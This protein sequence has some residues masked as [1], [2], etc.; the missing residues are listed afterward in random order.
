MNEDGVMRYES[1]IS[2]RKVD[3]NKRIKQS[4]RGLSKLGSESH[5]GNHHHKTEKT[6]LMDSEPKTSCSQFFT[7]ILIVI[8]T[9]LAHLICR[10]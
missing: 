9:F 3:Y 10:Q 2:R 7:F 4:R 6:Q 5:N 8:K 1:N